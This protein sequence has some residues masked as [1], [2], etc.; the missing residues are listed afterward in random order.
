MT[1]WCQSM[2]EK[3]YSDIEKLQ[4]LLSHWLQHNENHGAEYV[5]WAE[6]ARN[7]GHGKTAEFIEQALELMK[8]ADASLEKALDSV[9]G[10]GV[11]HHHHHHHHGHD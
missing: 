10:P 5:K 8:K 2:T 7:A 4:M 6:V 9:G 1:A 11:K 3:H